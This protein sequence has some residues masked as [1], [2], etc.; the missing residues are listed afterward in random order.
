MQQTHYALRNSSS[1][2][3]TLHG[4]ASVLQNGG[5][6]HEVQ[7]ADDSRSEGQLLCVLSLLSS[8]RSIRPV[9]HEEQQLPC[10]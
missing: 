10:H 7:R 9:Q 5:R 8:Q 1:T 3:G 4:G 2:G 6:S